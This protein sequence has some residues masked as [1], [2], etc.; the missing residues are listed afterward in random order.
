MRTDALDYDLPEEL[1]AQRPLARR[2]ESRLLVYERASG[3][4]RHRMFGDVRE[5]LAGTLVVVNDTRVLPARLHV[6][7][8]GG[9]RAEVLLLEPLG[10]GVWEALARPT[11]RLRPGTALGSVELLDHLGNGRWHVRL[12]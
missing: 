1:I 7:R 3:E 6:E 4:V 11:K 8:P 10:D 9:G 12:T 2:D 5:E